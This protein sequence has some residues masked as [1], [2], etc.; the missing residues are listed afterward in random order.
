MSDQSIFT[1]C[2][3]QVQATYGAGSGGST[4]NATNA[5]VQAQ[6]EALAQCV[7]DAL[8]QRQASD[9]LNV[10]HWLY[11]LAGSLVFIMQVGF[12][13]LCAGCVRRK[14]VQK[15]VGAH[16]I[17]GTR[18]G[19]WRSTE[20]ARAG[21]CQIEKDPANLTTCVLVSLLS[22]VATAPCSRTCWTR[23]GPPSPFTL[24]GTPSRSAG[25]TRWSA[26]PLSAPPTSC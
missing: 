8:E 6:Y 15:Y 18:G 20:R 21:I 13:M 2:Q 11:V 22:R 16:G 26:T 10:N 9:R 24:W 12:A 7:S 5:E 3:Q 19:S 4:V 1:A 17:G 14:N 25:R 23:A